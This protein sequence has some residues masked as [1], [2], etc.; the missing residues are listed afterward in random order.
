MEHKQTYRSF[1][2]AIIID[3]R[4]QVKGTRHISARRG[5]DVCEEGGKKDARRAEMER[6][7]QQSGPGRL[8]PGAQLVNSWTALS[9][10][11]S[12]DLSLTAAQIIEIYAARFSL[13]IAIRDL[14]QHFGFED[15]QATTTQPQYSGGGNSA[16][17]LFASGN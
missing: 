10:L 5:Y 7:Q 4:G 1:G 12:T 14:K 17:L 2:I 3:V 8:H 15:Y 13:E 9:I 16:A 11:V 6:S